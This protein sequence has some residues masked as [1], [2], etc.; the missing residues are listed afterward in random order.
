MKAV[1]NLRQL[2]NKRTLVVGLGKSGLAAARFLLGRGAVVLGNDRRENLEAV[3]A[4]AEL[5]EAGLEL[6][7][8]GHPVEVFCGVDVIVASPGVPPLDALDAAEASGVRVIS[9]VEL[10]AAYI[11]AALI[12]ITGTN[13][14]STVTSLVG[15]MLEAQSRPFFVGGN[16]GTPL[17]DAV[18]TPAAAKG[19]VVVV[20]VSSFQL[21][22]VQDFQPD[23]A[24]LLN[25]S[26]DHLDRYESYAAYVAAKGHIFR[27]QGR[28]DHAVV[29]AGD[30]VCRAIAKVGAAKVHAFGAGGEVAV[31][32][33]LALE[34]GTRR[35][36]G[37]PHIIDRVSG[38][39]VPVA[40]LRIRGAHNQANACAAALIARL[41]GLGAESIASGLSRFPGLPHR[42]YDLGEVAGVRYYDDSKATNVGAAVAALAGLEGESVVLIAGGRDKGGSYGPL[43]EALDG[44]RGVVTLGEAAENIE[45]ALEQSKLSIPQCRATTLEEAVA[46]AHGMAEVGDVVLLAPACSSFDMFPSYVARGE[47]FAVEVAALRLREGAKS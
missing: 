8:G 27:A 41:A 10:A 24:A 17:L 29:G 36:L 3:P 21:E 25:V 22:R 28:K 47:A 40:S 1:I 46:M 14:K 13:G 4:V 39:H 42:M 6:H 23:V 30:D 12:A 16:L 26:P 7:L 9:E 32:N 37:E 15:A 33:V 38:M 43:L 11:D 20:E 19:G 34:D 35:S 31:D 5:V 44:A 18:G 45:A 2:Q